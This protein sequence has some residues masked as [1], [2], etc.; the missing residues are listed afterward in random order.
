MRVVIAPDKFKGSLTAAEASQA[1]RNGVLDADPS[2]EVVVCPMADGGEGTVEAVAGATGAEVRT[3]EVSGPL[4]GQRV[5]ARWA[6]I[7]PG[8][9]RGRGGG[10]LP[11]GLTTAEPTGVV[12]MAQASGFSLV[13]AGESDPFVTTTL[14]TGEL[15]AAAMD[16]GCARVVVGVGGSATVD[17]GTGMARA[18]GFRFIDEAGGEVPLGGG[19]L[20][21]VR[22]ID[23]SGRDP[24]LDRVAVLVA[25]DVD[26][27]L[28]GEQGAARVFGPQ[29]GATPAQV[30]EL[31][32]GLENLGELMRRQLGV[33]VSG[34]PGAGAAGGLGAGLVAFCGAR[35]VSGIEL[36][37]GL[38]GLKEKIRG[39][40]LVLTGEGSFDSQ[41]ARGKA[42]AGVV[43]AALDEGVPAVIV[44]G[45]L[46]GPEVEHLGQG[47][48]VFSVSPGPM[49]ELEAM[50]RAAELLRYGTARLMRLLQ[51]GVGPREG[52]PG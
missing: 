5:A 9:L 31:E 24:R 18:L 7:K 17:G 19:A 26:N 36:V 28:L 35:V 38:V 16:A 32:R 47:A 22:S 33:E 51:L 42:P 43:A 14:G 15:I 1:M 50:S 23:A 37:S 20:T 3:E 41:T 6:L 4:P 45:R 44:A 12:E 40:D 49:A 8:G 11:G 34:T 52:V 10:A 39:A 27:P 13:P 25:S 2:A 46:A 48:A 29:K 30:E 21:R